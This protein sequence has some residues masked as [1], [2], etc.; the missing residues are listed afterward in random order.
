MGDDHYATC[1]RTG[2]RHVA[3]YRGREIARTDNPV[4]LREFHGRDYPPVIY[5]PAGDVAMELFERTSTSTHCPIKGDASYF[6]LAGEGE[7][8][9]DIAW[10]YEEPLAGVEAIRGHVAF[11]PGRIEVAAEQA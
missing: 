7:D 9:A 10:S 1:E 4:V 3:R 6:S 5:F 2:E 8:G 11:Y